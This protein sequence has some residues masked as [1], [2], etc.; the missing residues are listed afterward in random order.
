[1]AMNKNKQYQI[2]LI[3]CFARPIM[4]A[5]IEISMHFNK[6]G[7]QLHRLDNKQD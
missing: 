3:V 5:A 7:K 6:H 2:L 1:M 4:T